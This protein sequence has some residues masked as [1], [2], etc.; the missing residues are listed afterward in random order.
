LLTGSSLWHD[1]WLVEEQADGIFGWT[2]SHFQ[3]GL[4]GSQLRESL[5]LLLLVLTIFFAYTTSCVVCRVNKTVDDR[6]P[7]F[8]KNRPIN[9]SNRPVYRACDL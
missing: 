4:P 3:P 7:R 2:D 6:F 8:N 5:L 1:E 9:R